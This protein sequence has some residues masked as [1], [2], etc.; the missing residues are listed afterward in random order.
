MC[1]TEAS[2]WGQLSCR[3]C[4][5]P[6]TGMVCFCCEGKVWVMEVTAAQWLV[7]MISTRWLGFCVSPLYFA[8]TAV[9]FK[10]TTP[11]FLLCWLLR[12]SSHG[13]TSVP[14]P[15]P[16]LRGE[17]WALLPAVSEVSRHGPGGALQ[18]R[19]LLPAH[20]HDRARHWPE[21][22]LLSGRDSCCH[23]KALNSELLDS[24]TCK[25]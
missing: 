18:H 19:Q 7:L 11:H 20:L 12:S 25:S 1:I 21:G 4:A 16:V 13:S 10:T 5:T 9:F 8:Y 22:G 2:C 15:L 17:R 23:L 14:Y 6:G 24:L 3:L